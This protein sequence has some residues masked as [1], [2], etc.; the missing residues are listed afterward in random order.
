MVDKIAIRLFALSLFCGDIAAADGLGILNE[1][2]SPDLDEGLLEG[3]FHRTL[4][5]FR[6]T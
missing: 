4:G 1:R 6:F 3:K 5:E 2:L